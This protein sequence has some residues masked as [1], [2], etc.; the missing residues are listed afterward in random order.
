MIEVRQHTERYQDFLQRLSPS[1]RERVR[2]NEPMQ[3][4]TSFRIGGPADCLIEPQSPEELMQLIQAAKV[5][6]IPVTIMGNGSNLLV[7][8]QGIRGLV[9]TISKSYSGMERLSEEQTQE[10]F[11]AHPDLE[12]ACESCP[13]TPVYTDF[14]SP[15]C[16]VRVQAGTGV[17]ALA[18]WAREQG[19]AGMEFACGIPGSIG[20]G[21][22]MNA[23]A[24]GNSM[25]DVVVLTRSM[26][27]EG[28]L[29]WSCGAEHDFSYRRSYFSRAG[30]I[31]LESYFCLRPGNA[32][33][34]SALQEEYRCRRRTTQPLD[35]PSAGSMFKRPQGY[36]AG[37]LISD[38]GLKGY[39]IGDA[40]V[41]EKHAG[42]VVNL[43]A[44]RAEDVR[45]LVRF[46]QNR[47][48]ACF[49]VELEMEVR[50]IGDWDEV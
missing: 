13:N 14:G 31:I 1:I 34:V 6:D 7:A 45:A 32:E 9:L 23:G 39:R 44:A 47:I 8:D 10:L 5:D 17:T 20:G 36:F 33:E 41:S 11:L 48:F 43:G 28:E 3:R 21:V 30:Q 19:L 16:L 49:G 50:M 27:W 12:S 40:A 46:I 37:K 24:Y 35:L 29:Q 26:S 42:F 4:H 25:Q 18:S 15:P 38:A 2:L 22:F